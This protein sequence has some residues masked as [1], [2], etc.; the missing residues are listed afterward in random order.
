MRHVISTR[1]VEA[2]E[3]R[4]SRRRATVGAL[5][6]FLSG[7]SALPNRLP[8]DGAR[9]SGSDGRSESIAP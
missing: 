8:H 4:A 1:V 9:A 7:A 2:L 6:S 5:S 3:A